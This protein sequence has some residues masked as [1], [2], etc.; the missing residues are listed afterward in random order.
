MQ[1]SKILLAM[2]LASVCVAPGFAQ[3]P[4]QGGA[5]PGGAPAKSKFDYKPAF[6]AMDTNHD[7]KI[8][9]EE[10]TAAGM[11][12]FSLA[13]L[14]PMLDGNK[15]NFLTFEEFA[16]DPRFEIDFNKDGKITLEE[17]KKANNDAGANVEKNGGGPGG[18]GA[19][20]AGGAP[21]GGP[22]SGDAPAGG[23]PQ[24]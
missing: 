13:H 23:P 21:A 19:A 16:Q 10:W 3:A 1:I 8:S 4:P 24:Q 7:G 12:A 22:P 15:D 11:S 9:K 20:P 17:Y 14:F 18:G 6:D 2:S 5:A